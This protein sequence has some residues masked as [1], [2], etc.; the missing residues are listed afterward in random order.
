MKIS[1]FSPEVHSNKGF[2]TLVGLKMTQK[3]EN[4][5]RKRAGGEKKTGNTHNFYI[6]VLKDSF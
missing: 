4:G 5:K 2:V 3:K 1:P 6:A